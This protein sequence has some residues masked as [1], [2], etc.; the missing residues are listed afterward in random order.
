MGYVIRI[1]DVTVC[2]VYCMTCGVGEY[3]IWAAAV[4]IV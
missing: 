2:D 4:C 1:Y 3:A